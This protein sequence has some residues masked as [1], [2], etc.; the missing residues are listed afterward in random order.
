MKTS[1][2]RIFA[3]LGFMG[4]ATIWGGCFKDDI[5]N[6]PTEKDGTKPGPVSN[7][8]VK[9]VNGGATIT[10]K[11]PNSS[12]LLYVRAR[13]KANDV[14]AR[15][16]QVSYYS[17]SIELSGFAEK[18]EYE[19]TLTAV[20]RGEVESDPVI[21]KVHPETPIHRLVLPT[22]EIN[23]DFGGIFVSAQNPVREKI[24]VIVITADKNGEFKPIESKYLTTA[25]IGFSVRGYESKPR[26]FGVYVVDRW[27]NSSDT[28]FAD[29]TPLFE[30]MIE[31]SKFAEYPLPGDEPMD[32]GWALPFLW[33]DKTEEAN[34]NGFHTT[35][36]GALPKHVT[37]D[38]GAS[39]NLS[40]YKMWHRVNDW[41]AFSHGNPKRWKL[42]G[43]NTK[44]ATNGSFDGWTLIGEYETPTKPSG[45]PP[46]DNTPEDVAR[47]RQGFEFNI[48]SNTPK[49]RYIRIQVEETLSGANFWHLMEITFWGQ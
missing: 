23:P 38:M 42:W 48:P 37:F 2:T 8:Q 21:V 46:Y 34:G 17:N 15:Q 31:K 49:V 26:K 16:T 47:A 13:Y 14:T 12:N 33:D 43:T 30:S 10:Y 25:E 20:S 44:P 19:V 36:V 22:V 6:G 32:Y 24:G 9:N 18:K 45:R 7:V 11:L 4:L 29:I 3:L 40:R 5:Y 27:G 41:M 39:Y 1:Q 28:L 35:T